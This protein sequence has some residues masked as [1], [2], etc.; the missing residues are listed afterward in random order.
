MRIP[1]ASPCGPVV[2]F[3]TH[4]S[5]FFHP[6]VLAY[7]LRNRAAHLA[8]HG[9]RTGTLAPGVRDELWQIGAAATSVS[10][11]I[12]PQ[13]AAT[14]LLSFSK[15]GQSIPYAVKALT[16]SFNFERARPK[17]IALT[18]NAFSRQPRVLS[19]VDSHFWDRLS[20]AVERTESQFTPQDSAACAL[21][22]TG[23]LAANRGKHALGDAVPLDDSTA[24][25]LR[26]VYST[27][28]QYL[29]RMLNELDS[30]SF[31][32]R[33]LSCSLQAV[34][35]SRI[36]APTLI[37]AILNKLKEVIPTSLHGIDDVLFT[38]DLLPPP[39]LIGD[40]VEQRRIKRDVARAEKAFVEWAFDYLEEHLDCL[41]DREL[42]R[43]AAACNRLRS[44]SSDNFAI[45]FAQTWEAL[46]SASEEIP[47]NS[48]SQGACYFLR[49]YEASVSRELAAR[50]EAK[51]LSISRVSDVCA[52]IGEML[53]EYARTHY[54]KDDL[55]RVEEVMDIAEQCRAKR[56][57]KQHP[58]PL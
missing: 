31:K 3:E 7:V 37:I 56:T 57:G 9:R 40:T 1:S 44:W 39:C 34:Y 15:L 11:N 10:A 12:E 47:P 18:L 48:L 35:A 42:G 29:E 50:D 33:D 26:N 52:R 41:R 25:K 19:H 53:H 30:H 46:L 32:T 45:K 16:A 5:D 36:E 20:D 43:I 58:R 24:R 8:R 14:L 23:I 51:Q 22:I 21:S 49:R 13:T 28:L 27:V 6:S 38:L 17:A 4:C 54:S 2:N 55:L